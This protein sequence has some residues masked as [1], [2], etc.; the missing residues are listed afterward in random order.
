MFC[1]PSQYLFITNIRKYYYN[2]PICISITNVLQ[3]IDHNKPY[4]NAH[5]YII[6]RQDLG[7]IQL[8]ETQ[9][10]IDFFYGKYIRNVVNINLFY[11]KKITILFG[12]TSQT[13]LKSI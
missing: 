2:I 11:H 5:Y 12:I 13:T 1:F 7:I 3:I 10:I 9:I 6:Y 4:L 8:R